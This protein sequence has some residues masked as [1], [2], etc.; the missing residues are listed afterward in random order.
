ME[1]QESYEYWSKLGDSTFKGI[2]YQK[3]EGGIRIS[4]YLDI[5]SMDGK[6]VYI[7]TVINQNQ[8]QGVPFAL[9]SSDK[10]LVFENPTHDF[11]KK[12]I[13]NPVDQ[14]EIEVTVTDGKKTFS[15]KLFRHVAS[16]SESPAF[17]TPIETNVTSKVD[18]LPSGELILKQEIVIGAPVEMLWKSYTTGEAWKKWVTPVVE[19]D[20]KI[21]GTI[22]SH[23]DPQAAIGDDGTIVI[24]VL[25][26]IPMKQI[27]MQAEIAENFPEFMKGE[28]ENMYSIVEFT[29]LEAN[30]TRVT[31]YGMGYK[32]EERWHDLMKFFI[33]GNEMTLNKLK[34]FA[35]SNN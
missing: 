32:N 15:Y 9:T 10:A 31:L 24:H 12:I 2:S 20:F 25:N 34:A 8:G 22:R 11:P 16:G 33:Q 7:A 21:N 30:L 29:P 18:T 5:L 4:E 1:N 26:Y 3:K 17:Q 28:E 35:E 6:I 23:Y 19:M 13:Y 27:T 14:N